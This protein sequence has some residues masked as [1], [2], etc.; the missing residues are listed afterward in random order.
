MSSFVTL[1]AVAG[2]TH[3]AL[4]RTIAPVRASLSEMA[5]K[6]ARFD[7]FEFGRA[8]KNVP[9]RRT[10]SAERVPVRVVPA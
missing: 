10:L 8:G 7:L 4:S 5:R 6:T 2:P 9:A 3:A 1:R